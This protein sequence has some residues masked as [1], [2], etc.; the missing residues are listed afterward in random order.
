MMK[1]ICLIGMNN[2]VPTELEL[3][4]ISSATNISSLRD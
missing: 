3:Y 2:A 1:N 4:C